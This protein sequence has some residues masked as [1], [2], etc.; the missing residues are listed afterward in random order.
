MDRPAI[1]EFPRQTQMSRE[2]IASRRPSRNLERK[3]YRGFARLADLSDIAQ[4]LTSQNST[5]QNIIPP[6]DFEACTSEFKILE[7]KIRVILIWN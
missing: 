7:S 2:K 4:T 5:R 3:F 1:L 6:P